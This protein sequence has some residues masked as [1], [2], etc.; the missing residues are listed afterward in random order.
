MADLAKEYGVV[1]KTI[2][3]LLSRSGQ[4]SGVLLELAKIK[5][6]KEALLKIVGELIV[7]QRLEK[8]SSVVM[9]INKSAPN[10]SK[11][12][13]AKELGISRQS[14]YYKPKLPEKDLQLKTDIE[15]IMID[16]KAYGHKRVAIAL[17]INKKRILRV[18]KLFGL[19]PKR[20]R[21][22]LDKPK[23]LNQ[24]PITIPNLIMET[25]IEAPN[26]VWVSDFTHLLYYGK[27]V[28]L[29]TIEDIFTRQIVGWEI[30]MKHN[31]DLINQTLLNAL[32]RYPVPK[33][34][35]SDQGSEY[36]SQDYQNLLKK[37]HISASMSDKAS[38]WQNG[39]KESFYSEFKLELGHPECYPT[40]GELIE[41]VARQ[42][43][44]YNN[45][46]IHTALKCP[47]NVFAVK[48]HLWNH[49]QDN[50][51]RSPII[52]QLILSENSARLSV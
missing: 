16:N 14:L 2:Y 9:A 21:K 32:T 33:I 18:M 3:N 24:A 6:E 19:K 26:E 36:R 10:K 8:K 45:K 46:R 37:F 4:N 42:I 15:K 23:D 1:P 11:K 7:D 22:K 28:Y 34:C 49:N 35:H 51:Q 25:I 48:F 30:S 50:N 29:A 43:H 52:N 12:E 40:M 47:P 5:R 39:Y 41:A 13:L 27:F 31:A 38:P 44:Y 20:S 17:N